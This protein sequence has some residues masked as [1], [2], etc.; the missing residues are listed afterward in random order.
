MGW[1]L[2]FETLATNIAVICACTE[3]IPVLHAVNLMKC[4]WR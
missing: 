2:I 4:N 1:M 3:E